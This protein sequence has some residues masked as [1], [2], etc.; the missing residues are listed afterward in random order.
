MSV[1]TLALPLSCL[2]YARD[3]PEKFTMHCI[4]FL[5]LPFKTLMSIMRAFT[6]LA[7]FCSLTCILGTY[8]VVDICYRH[9]PLQIVSL[10]V[11]PASW[12]CMLIVIG[13]ETKIYIYEFRWYVR[14][15]VIYVLIGEISMFNL[16]LSVREYYDRYDT[17]LYLV[18]CNCFTI[19]AS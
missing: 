3:R 6:V 11:E 17:C 13:V 19:S 7:L 10:L 14:F 15:A 18:T 2:I 1:S 16:V 5:S 9:L 8:F 12:C 4:F